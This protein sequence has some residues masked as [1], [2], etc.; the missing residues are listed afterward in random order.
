MVYD[1]LPK[2]RFAVNAK[3]GIADLA[4]ARKILGGVHTAATAQERRLVLARV[5]CAAGSR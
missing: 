1:H 3:I 4:Q 5:S 2:I